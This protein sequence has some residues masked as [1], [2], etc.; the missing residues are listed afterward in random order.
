EKRFLAN[1]SQI[2]FKIATEIR[3]VIAVYGYYEEHFPHVE[4]NDMR[5]SF[6]TFSPLLDKMTYD[7]D[8]DPLTTEELDTSG[9]PE[10]KPNLCSDAVIV[11]V[12]FNGTNLRKIVEGRGQAISVPYAFEEEHIQ[13]VVEAV[14]YK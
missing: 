13:E 12:G 14:L 1:N 4:V 10:L 11:A 3:A 9:L 2:I 6:P 5:R 8:A 7:K